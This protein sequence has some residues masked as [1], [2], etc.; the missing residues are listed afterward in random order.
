MILGY[1]NSKHYLHRIYREGGQAALDGN[2]LCP[3]SLGT[4]EN[5]WWWAGWTEGVLAK[6]S[7]GNKQ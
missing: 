6:V 2:D 3:Y 4:K 1:K 5:D 7:R